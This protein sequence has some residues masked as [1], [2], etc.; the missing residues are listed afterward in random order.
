MCVM[1]PQST[2]LP[3]EQIHSLFLTL[4]SLHKETLLQIVAHCADF[5]KE[6]QRLNQQFNTTVNGG[7]GWSYEVCQLALGTKRI[8]KGMRTF[9]DITD[10]APATD[11][12]I[13]FH[14]SSDRA[15]LNYELMKNFLAPIID[16]CTIE[17]ET[18]CIRYKD[19]R[20]LT[21]FIDGTE[22]PKGDEERASVAL[23]QDGNFA[24]GSFAFVQKYEHNLNRW[25]Q[26]SNQEKEHTIGRTMADSVELENKKDTAHISR[27]VIEENGEE[28]EI[29]RHSKP[30]FSVSSKKGLFFL[31][32]TNNLDH[33]EKMLNRMYG[34]TS[35]GL[36]D[37]LLQHTTPVSGAIF[38]FP[39]SEILQN[40]I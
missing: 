16:Q 27:V 10:K 14:I 39:P 31:A 15:D 36:T 33:I 32:Y 26:M 30:F 7:I 18:P 29:V 11:G 28:L 12:D 1:T 2:I 37:S 23:I 35:D 38:F 22:N 24:G 9:S 4:N 8:P 21:G 19:S 17:D 13:F 34:Q 3:E 40:V 6:I 25:E 5:P 20:D